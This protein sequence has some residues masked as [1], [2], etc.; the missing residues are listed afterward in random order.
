MKKKAIERIPYIG[1]AQVIRK[2]AVKYVGVTAEQEIAGEDHLLL[3]CIRTV[4][5]M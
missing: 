3:K 1:L 5:R 4:Q 2:K